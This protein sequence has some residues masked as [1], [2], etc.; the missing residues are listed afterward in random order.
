[1][2]ASVELRTNSKINLFLRVVGGRVDGYHELESIFH[3]V[4]LADDMRITLTHTGRVDVEMRAVEGFEGPLPEL[5]ENLAFLAAQAL[6][7]RGIEHEGLHIEIDK[8][9]PVGGGLGGGS[10]N[11]AGVIVGLNHL[12][13]LELP[14]ES[15]VEVGATIGSDVPYCIGGGTALVMGRGEAMTP[16]PAPQPLCF[17]LAMSNDPL[18]TREVYAAYDEAQAELAEASSSA[19]MALALGAGDV[20]EIAALVHNDLERGAFALRPQLAELKKTLVDSGCLGAGLTGSGPTL[21]GLVEDAEHGKRVADQ[22][23]SLFDRVEVAASAPECVE[24]V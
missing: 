3:G 4:A 11:A 20:P 21:F 18:L 2:A 24:L 19:P 1:M 15:L 16:L 6:S 8:R 23:R 17:V 12:L 7:D 22:V 14:H 13:G 9:I 5:T 10:G